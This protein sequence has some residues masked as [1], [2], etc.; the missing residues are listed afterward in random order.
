[1]WSDYENWVDFSAEKP[2]R[3]YNHGQI[4]ILLIFDFSSSRTW[5]HDWL[6]KLSVSQ[7]QQEWKTTISI[8]A[9]KFNQ[10]LKHLVNVWDL[11]QTALFPNPRED[12]KNI[13]SVKSQRYTILKT[14]KC[15]WWW[16]LF[17]ASRSPKGFSTWLYKPD[18]SVPNNYRT[19][20]IRGMKLFS[21]I[22]ATQY[23]QKLRKSW[24]NFCVNQSED[25]W[26]QHLL[27]LRGLIKNNKNTESYFSVKAA[28]SA[29]G[30]FAKWK[31]LKD[32]RT[33]SWVALISAHTLLYIHLLV[34][35]S[36]VFVTLHLVPYCDLYET[37]EPSPDL[38]S[39][40][41]STQRSRWKPWHCLYSVDHINCE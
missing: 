18:L 3:F 22:W 36:T 14:Q 15:R 9:K 31:L 2:G 4:Q 32:V 24:L 34:L 28:S 10:P 19:L 39:I 35:T 29:V 11:I 5:S 1:M 6:F 26:W 16:D 38:H 8:S 40:T 20:E 27:S 7:S 33:C 23:I 25:R 21:R 12:G 37:T 30:K 41:G 17:T 13:C